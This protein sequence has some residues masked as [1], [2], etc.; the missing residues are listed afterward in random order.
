MTKNDSYHILGNVETK[1]LSTVKEGV[2]LFY[3]ET[4]DNTEELLKCPC[5][6]WNLN[7]TSLRIHLNI[8]K[9]NHRISPFRKIP[10]IVPA[11]LAIM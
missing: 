11:S 5:D 3:N 2:V 1:R 9:Y 4:N 8:I 10:L 6:S 7:N